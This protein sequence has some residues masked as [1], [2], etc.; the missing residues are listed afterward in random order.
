MFAVILIEP[1]ELLDMLRLLLD[2][3]YVRRRCLHAVGQLVTLDT[4]CQVAVAW[5]PR[6][7]LLVHLRKEI[8]LATL[9]VRR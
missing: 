5:Q 2:V 8:E 6:Q 4:R 9:R 7:V 1:V 3:E